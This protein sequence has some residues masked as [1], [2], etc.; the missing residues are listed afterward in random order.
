MLSQYW[1][2]SSAEW[3]WRFLG[4]ECL[5]ETPRPCKYIGMRL[6]GLAESVC[7]WCGLCCCLDICV[8]A[9]CVVVLGCTVDGIG[10]EESM[11]S[12]KNV[13]VGMLCLCSVSPKH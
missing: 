8:H 10:C 5:P 11:W 6:V 1:V 2:A 9:C 4:G 3:A 12:K 13:P 7:E